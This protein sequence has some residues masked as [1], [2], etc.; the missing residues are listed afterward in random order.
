MRKFIKNLIGSLVGYGNCPNC[1]DSWVWK[2]TGS[3]P[4]EGKEPSV[5][6]EDGELI[7]TI[8]YVKSICICT[9]CLARLDLLD[10]K[11]ILS[12]LKKSGWKNEDLEKAEVSIKY[13][14]EQH[15]AA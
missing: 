13:F 1:G 9:E 10:T 8:G 3:I 2:D 7:F 4:Y 6:V 5:K 11:K 15:T 12:D 14:K